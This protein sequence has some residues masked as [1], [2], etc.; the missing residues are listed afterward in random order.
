MERYRFSFFDRL[1]L[2]WQTMPYYSYAHNAFLLLSCLSKRSRKNLEENYEAFL[3]WMM[4]NLMEVKIGDDSK[5]REY[6]LPWDLFKF[7]IIIENEEQ[8]IYFK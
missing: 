8:A 5:G 7:T 3:N 1:G 4:Q 2:M 6:S